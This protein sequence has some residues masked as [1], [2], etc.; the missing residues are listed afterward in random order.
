MKLTELGQHDSI[1]TYLCT[2]IPN[3]EM[4]SEEYRSKY[5]IKL[6]YPRDMYRSLEERKWDDEDNSHEDI[7]MVCETDSASRQ[8]LAD[9]LSYAWMMSQFHYSGYTQLISRYLYHMKGVSYR[10]FYDKLYHALKTDPVG[11]HLLENVEEILINYLTH[12]EIPSNEKWGNVIALTLSESYGGNEIYDNADYFISLGINIGREISALDP[13]IEELQKAF[14]KNNKNKYPYSIVSSV[15]IDR[16]E[17]A[18]VVYEIK[19]R[20]SVSHQQDQM[21]E[22]WLRKTDIINITNPYVEKF[23]KGTYKRTVIPIIST[24]TTVMDGRPL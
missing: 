23:I 10:T 19:D 8:D 2:V 17:N 18:H 14:I 9:C 15:D 4:D 12:G 1:K 24:P 22:K 6:I 3:S 7:A 16:W 21:Y 20:I 13:S 5:G 11:R